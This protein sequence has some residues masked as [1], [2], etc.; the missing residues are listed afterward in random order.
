VSRAVKPCPP[1]S[2]YE[3]PRGDDPLDAIELAFV[4]MWIEIIAAEIRQ[5]LGAGQ[6]I[7]KRL[8][9]D[10]GAGS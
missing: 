4:R 8:D 3:P 6:S 5:E 10:D 7:A 2:P 9:S 1:L